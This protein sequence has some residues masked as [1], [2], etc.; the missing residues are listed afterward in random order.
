MSCPLT[1]ISTFLLLSLGRNYCFWD[2]PFL[3]FF[4]FQKPKLFSFQ[5][6]DCYRT[7]WRLFS[8]ASCALNLICINAT[9]GAGTAYPSGAPTFTTGF[10]LCS[11]CSIFSFLCSVLWIVVCPS[12][13]FLVAIVLSGLLRFPDSDYPTTSVFSISFSGYVGDLW[14]LNS[15]KMF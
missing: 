15:N 10:E 14:W 4:C 6:F 2:Y 8:N 7:W 1:W 13:L 11:C 3:V 9:C 12:V 5:S